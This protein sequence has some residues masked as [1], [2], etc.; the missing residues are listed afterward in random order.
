MTFLSPLIALITAGIALPL[1][2]ALYFLKLRRKELTIS[3]TLLWRKAIQDLQVNAPF[4]KLRKSLLLLL[5]L[6]LLAALL[7]AIARPTLRDTAKTGRRVVILIDRSTSMNATDIRPTR[8]DEAKRLA[9]RIVDELGEDTRPGSGGRSSIG[10]MLVSFSQRAQVMQPFTND[11]SLLRSSIRAIEGTDEPGRLEGALRLVEPFAVGSAA[12]TPLVVYIVSDGR[13]EKLGDLSLRGADVRFVRVGKQAVV[14]PAGAGTVAVA[15]DPEQWPDNL[16]IVSLAARRDFKKPE[17]VQVFVRLANFGAKRVSAAVTLRV[18]GQAYRTLAVD[19]PPIDAARGEAGSQSVQFDLELT[20]SALVEVTHDHGDDLLAD[21]SAAL[22]IVPPQRLRVLLVT[23][24]DAFI[25]QSI[26]ALGVRKLIAMTPKRYEDQDPRRLRRGTGG[27]GDEGFDAI[28]FDSYSPKEV[29]AIDSLYLGG[30]PPLE[31][32]KLVPARKDDTK[33]Q[34]IL[35]W[36]RD[37]ALTRYVS[38]DDVVMSEPGRLVLPETAEVLATAQSGPVLAV[39]QSRGVHHVVGSFDVLKTNWPMQV[40]FPVFVSNAVTWL[41]L[42][43]QSEA[44]VSFRP[45]EAASVPTAVG[46]RE[47]RYRGPVPLR[48]EPVEGRAVLPVFQ[49]VGVYTAEDAKSVS[50]PFDRLAVNLTDTTESD[51]RPAERLEVGTSVVNAQPG[52]LAVR[53]E[54]WP[55]FAWAALALLMIEWVVYTRRMHL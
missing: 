33:A 21:N 20:G 40:S 23:E 45:G 34:L 9:L 6:L 18:D 47:M 28:V 53:R 11:L 10:A 55:W 15:A 1:L 38:L 42:G 17:Q 5:Q 4:Q 24:G 8:L 43:G 52:E 36:K 32:L 13:V 22:L 25:E 51:L 49:H 44:G 50:P 37:H 12:D 27:D 16:A 31:G 39:V 46:V 41:A 19:V 2:V 48:A 7:F 30:A 54:V 29:P 3:S 14:T 35:A 26:R